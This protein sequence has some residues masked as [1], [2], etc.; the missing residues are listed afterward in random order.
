MSYLH[1]AVTRVSRKRRKPLIKGN[2]EERKR[3]VSL[4]LPKKPVQESFL[5][6]F[7]FRRSHVRERFLSFR[8]RL[9]NFSSW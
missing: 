6:T 8:R 1:E 5:L 4:L 3:G 9:G 2:S 7:I